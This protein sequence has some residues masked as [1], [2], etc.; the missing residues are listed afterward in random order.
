MVGY[1]C[2]T[3]HYIDDEWKSQKRIVKYTALETPHTGVAMFS[4]VEKFMRVEDR[5]QTIFCDP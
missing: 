4:M 1:I 3:V 2:I 5:R